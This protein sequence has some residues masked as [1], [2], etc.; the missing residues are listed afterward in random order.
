VNGFSRNRFGGGLGWVWTE[1]IW[2]ETGGGI[3]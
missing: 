2:T 1:L 3:L